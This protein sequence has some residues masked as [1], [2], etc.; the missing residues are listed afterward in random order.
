MFIIKQNKS[1]KNKYKAKQEHKEQV[2]IRNV[3]TKEK[4][5]EDINEKNETKLKP[6]SYY[7]HENTK[8]RNRMMSKEYVKNVYLG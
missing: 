7:N 5:Q 1:I 2:E 8:E 6:Y 3:L 4:K